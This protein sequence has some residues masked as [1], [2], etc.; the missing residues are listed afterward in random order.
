[1]TTTVSNTL[2]VVTLTGNPK[3]GSRTHAAVTAVA[4]RLADYVPTEHLADIDLALWAGGP[5]TALPDAIATAHEAVLTADVLIVGTPVYKGAYTGLLKGFLDLLPPGTLRHTVAVPVT[6]S[7]APA[8]RLLAEQALR[9]VLAELGASLPTPGLALEESELGNLATIVDDWVRANA[10]LVSAV[11]RSFG[12]V[13][14]G[15]R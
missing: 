6:L 15:A 1:M 4:T 11:A 12:L 8:H 9:P 5:F 13:E 10:F 14:A 2:R 3:P 7:A